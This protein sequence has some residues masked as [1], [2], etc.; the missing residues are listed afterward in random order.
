MSMRRFNLNMLPVLDALLR[1][2]NVTRAGKEIGLSQSATSHALLRLRDQLGDDLLIQSGRTLSLTHRAKAIA[3]PLEAALEAIERLLDNRTFDP[4]TSVR[5]FKIGTADHISALLLPG[6]MRAI[7]DSTGLIVHTDWVD[8]DVGKKLRSGELD[9]AILPLG[10][11]DSDLHMCPLFEDELVL[12]AAASNDNV[13]EGM[14]LDQFLSLPYAGFGREMADFQS[15]A[16]GQ[17]SRSQI[18]PRRVLSVTEFMLLPYLICRSTYVT[19][20]HRRMA[21]SVMTT[22][23]I[24]IVSL[25]FAAE[26]VKMSLYWS[27]QADSE[28]GHRWFREQILLARDEIC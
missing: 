2:R 12:V 28:A 1:H 18:L 15:F 10:Q 16:D 21:E 23:P 24:K 8:R 11:V 9:V 14:T 4:K 5:S 3:G 20:L 13:T 6:I 7:E 27:H 17:M 25:P 26:R 19:I 22:S